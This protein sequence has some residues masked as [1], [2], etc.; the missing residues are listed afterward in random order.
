MYADYSMAYIYLNPQRQQLENAQQ[1]IALL[2][3]ERQRLSQRIAVID[4]QIGAWEAHIKTMQPLIDNES[5]AVRGK[6]LADLCRVAL[7]AYGQWVSAVQVRD[8]LSQLGIRLQYSNP[9]AVLHTT[10]RRVGQTARDAEGN[11]FYAQKGLS[12]PHLWFLI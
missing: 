6:S 9:M 4:G 12:C 5:E 8:Y 11:T 7:A 2:Q 3:A 1:Q 10:L